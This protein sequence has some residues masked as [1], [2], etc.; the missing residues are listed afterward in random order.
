[1]HNH[2]ICHNPQPIDRPIQT[3]PIINYDAEKMI[4]KHTVK[5]KT[6]VEIILHFADG[7]T[8]SK[9]MVVGNIETILYL[10]DARLIEVTGKIIDIRYKNIRT[11]QTRCICEAIPRQEAY[12]IID[13][14]NRYEY[15][16]HT[17]ETSTIRDFYIEED[18]PPIEE[19]SDN[20][21]TSNDNTENSDIDK[22]DSNT[23]FPTNPE[24]GEG[25][26]NMYD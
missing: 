4:T 7:S 25:E 10:K 13:S 2:D 15:N 17:I 22:D 6:T 14:S 16:I 11:P 21:D 23:N 18:T 3:N 12:I 5:I 9:N 26:V 20:K 8:K 1:M 24:L 19:D